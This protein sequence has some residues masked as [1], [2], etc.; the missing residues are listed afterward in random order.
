MRRI[1]PTLFAMKT[2]SNFLPLS[3][4]LAVV[5]SFSFATSLLAQQP[6]QQQTPAQPVPVVVQPT[7]AQYKVIDIGQITVP[8]RGS[9][10]ASLE[11]LLND[12]AAQGWRLVSISGSIMIMSR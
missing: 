10:A 5:F 2:L 11:N 8:P 7:I 4:M 9:P 3:T 1:I 12:L 6:L